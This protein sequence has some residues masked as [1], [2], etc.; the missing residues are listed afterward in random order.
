MALDDGRLG[1]IDFGQVGRLTTAQQNTL[2]GLL[3]S[4]VMGDV[5]GIARTVLKMG[6]A[7]GRVNMAEMRERCADIRGR[8]LK[9]N[10]AEVDAALF[11][12]ELL[13]AGQYF[14][15]RVT[16]EYAILAK[17]AVTCE[18]VLRSVDPDLDI[19]GTAKPFARRLLKNRYSS[20]R[21]LETGVQTFSNVASLLRDLPQNLDQILL[22]LNTG[23]LTFEIR[24]KPMEEL[25]SQLNVVATR[26]FMAIMA[27]GL[28]I[29]ASIMV[30]D[31][32]WRVAGIP[33]AT[34]M[35]FSLAMFLTFVGLAWHALGAGSGKLS[36]SFLAK[37]L[38]RRR[39]PP[40]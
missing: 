40:S 8:H 11:V 26:I 36:L 13:E 37:L 7:V 15:I 29:S 20:K 12:Q 9:K 35:S 30:N 27:A 28:F 38:E 24:N 3:V 19:L 6:R 22:D 1:V 23:T 2:V 17:G 31:D 33:V 5:D 14:R 34:V 10:L 16:S 25:G 4:I 32:P 39:K 18:G 21:L